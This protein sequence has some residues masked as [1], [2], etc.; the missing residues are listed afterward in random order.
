MP[1]DLKQQFYEFSM[2]RENSIITV[3]VEGLKFK[4]KINLSKDAFFKK[5]I[6][7]HE[8][9]DFV[10]CFLPGYTPFFNPIEELFGY[11]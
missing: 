5:E 3:K 11:L 7:L 6:F 9:F 10:Y 8:N 1:D 4:T 2:K